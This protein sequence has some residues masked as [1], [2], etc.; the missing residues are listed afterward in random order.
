MDAIAE[1]ETLLNGGN[2]NYELA[3]KAVGATAD[4]I[5]LAVANGTLETLYGDIFENEQDSLLVHA[6]NW[7]NNLNDEYKQTV[8]NDAQLTSRGLNLG[9]SSTYIPVAFDEFGQSLKLA[10]TSYNPQAEYEDA[11]NYLYENGSPLALAQYINANGSNLFKQE[12]RE[13]GFTSSYANR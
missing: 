3:G 6:H 1:F 13:K 5:Q 11:L 12:L 8:A 4:Q 9:A 2:A 7:Y 10:R